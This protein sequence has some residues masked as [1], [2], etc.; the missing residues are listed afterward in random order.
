MYRVEE[1]KQMLIHAHTP[2]PKEIEG[3]ESGQEL[4][5]QFGRFGRW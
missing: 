4:S 5:N 1:T 3:M 2:T